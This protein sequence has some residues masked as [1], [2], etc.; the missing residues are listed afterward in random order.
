M[1]E[2][3]FVAGCLVILLGTIHSVL[4]EILIFRK[5]RI[6]GLIPTDGGTILK[7]SDVRIL[8]ASW[9]LVTLFGWAIAAMLF[10]TSF[11]EISVLP[12]F[13]IKTVVIFT[14]LG[15]A[16]VL[17]ATKGKHP[18]WIVLLVI[19]VLCLFS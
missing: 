9:H 12:A 6:S 16:L 13:I 3:T 2:Y 4:G 18:G 17:F 15:S 11:F 10:G 5:M 8:W 1:F 7:E 19:S 14:F